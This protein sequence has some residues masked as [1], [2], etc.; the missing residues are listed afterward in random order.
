LKKNTAKKKLQ[1]RKYGTHEQKINKYTSLHMMMLAGSMR[2]D[3][4]PCEADVLL[5]SIF[6]PYAPY[7]CVTK[8]F[9]PSATYICRIFLI[10]PY[11]PYT[12][13]K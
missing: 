5:P 1:K 8:H 3:Q 12:W 2:L 7:I 10:L 13:N 11:A 4:I 6:F 9:P